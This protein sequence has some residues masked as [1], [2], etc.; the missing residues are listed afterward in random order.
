MLTGSCF[1]K[2]QAFMQSLQMRWPVPGHIGLSMHDE[3]QRADRVAVACAACAS[4][5]SSRRADSR[6]ARCRAG[7]TLTVAVLCRA[8]PF[9]HESLSRS[10]QRRSSAIS[11]ERPR[12]ASCARSV[13][14]KPSRR[15]SAPSGPIIASGSARLGPLHARRGASSRRSP[16]SGRSPSPVGA[17]RECARRTSASALSTVG[18]A[19]LLGCGAGLLA[20]EQRAAGAGDR[21]LAIGRSSTASA[22][23]VARRSHR[24]RRRRDVRA[25]FQQRQRAAADEIDLEAEQIVLRAG[26]A[27]RSPMPARRPRTAAS[28]KRLTCGAIATSRFDSATGGRGASGA[29]RY[30]SHSRQNAGSAA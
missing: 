27:R 13:S 29:R 28:T 26:R 17:D 11:L 24:L 7:S 19:R 10:W 9:E 30:A 14:L 25:A 18:A 16:E 12:A 2:M 6:R 4:R 22:R 8:S 23:S 21:E 3:R 15:R 20:I 5:G 1:W